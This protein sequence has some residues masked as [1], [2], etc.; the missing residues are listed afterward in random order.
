MV[1][2]KPNSHS[3]CQRSYDAS[4]KTCWKICDANHWSYASGFLHPHVHR[5]APAKSQRNGVARENGAG[6]AF[7]QR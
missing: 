6:T 1:P 3:S 2:T 7:Q 4:A 5:L